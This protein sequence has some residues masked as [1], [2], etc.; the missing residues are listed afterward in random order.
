MSLIAELRVAGEPFALSGALGAALAAGYFET[1]RRTDL[2]ALAEEF[3][4]SEQAL[5]ERLRRGVAAVLE[6]T[7]GELY[8]RPGDERAGTPGTLSD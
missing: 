4:I 6:S 2:E 8:E 3:D 1:P 5:S 7:I